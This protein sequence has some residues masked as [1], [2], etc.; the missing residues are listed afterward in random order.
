MKLSICTA[1]QL[2]YV[3]MYR[4]EARDA[5]GRVVLRFEALRTEAELQG[6]QR[7]FTAR[8]LT[9]VGEVEELVAPAAPPA[10]SR[11]TINQFRDKWAA[12]ARG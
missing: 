1:R 11:P 5:D 8:G 4:V 7:R 10:A 2:G 3:E 12:R 9:I 6:L